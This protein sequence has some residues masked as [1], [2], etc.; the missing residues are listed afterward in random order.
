MRSFNGK[1]VFLRHPSWNIECKMFVRSFV[2]SDLGSLVAKCLM[3]F[4][5]LIFWMAYLIDNVLTS[6]EVKLVLLMRPSW[7]TERK[8]FVMS[9]VYSDPG[10][11]FAK[12]LTNFLRLIFWMALLIK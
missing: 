10:S 2:Y 5:R 9:F 4:L 7:N 1:L 3:N 6:I 12:P 8:M 11:V